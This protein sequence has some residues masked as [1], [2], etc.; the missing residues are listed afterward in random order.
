MNKTRSNVRQEFEAWWAQYPR[1]IGK[2]AAQ[3]EYEK[4]RRLAEATELVEGVE[5][6]K[7]SKPDYADWCHPKT[8][9]HQ[10]R[11]MDEVPT[12]GNGSRASWSCPHVDRCANRGMCQQA[13][14][15]GRPVRTDA[16]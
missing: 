16:T 13:S 4:A 2:L 3:R 6:Y 15:L 1:K 9:L 8:W 10:G 7:Q 5:R 14:I 12:N 11:W